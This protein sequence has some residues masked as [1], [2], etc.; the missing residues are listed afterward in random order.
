MSAKEKIAKLSVTA[1]GG[2][3]IQSC[4]ITISVNK[5]PT[6]SLTVLRQPDQKV[7]KPM[8]EEVVAAIRERQQKRLAGLVAPDMVISADDGV[9][10]K[11]DFV[12]Y[13]I[14]PVIQINTVSTT[15]QFTVLG[16]DGMLDALDLSVYDAGYQAARGEA[17]T[18]G[19]AADLI[20]DPIPAADN[21]Q[22]TALISEVS[23]I[24]YGN[25][26]PVRAKEPHQSMQE[27]LDQQ[28]G[29][30]SG[31]PI[32]L[33]L[34]ILANSN[35]VYESWAEAQKTVPG[36]GSQMAL[37]V[38]QILRQ[39][40]GG[41][42]STANALMATYQMYYIPSTTESGKFER[43]DKKV[44][45]NPQPLNL[46]VTGVS[47]SDGNHSLLPIGGVVMMTPAT[48]GVRPESTF[49][50]GT[51]AV[52]AQYPEKLLTGFIQREMPPLWMIGSDG[53]PIV[54]SSIDTK[55]PDKLNLSLP[56]YEKRKTGA[57]DKK[58]EIDNSNNS[59]LVELCK[60]MFNEMQLAHSTAETTIPLDLTQEVGKR[61]TVNILS[62]GSFTAFVSNIIHSIDL[63]QGKELNSFTQISFTHVR[64]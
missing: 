62:G 36:M 41:F 25:Y 37:R 46:S 32:N 57:A 14:V 39:K 45:E 22:V 48:P 47:V 16:V 30:N 11:L 40:V 42:W 20:L 2:Y 35:V 17:S 43:S 31:L 63:R 64:Y 44:E 55:K 50:P 49:E 10:G 53:S 38:K 9:G 3:S 5:V 58:D 23:K 19:R 15:D 60:V 27:L 6:A 26:G 33:W 56:D 12:G 61:V 28:H 8:S 59:V 24:L 4:Q 52:A 29:V 7:R 1:T 13:Q 51:N 21:G 34:R 54:G 18:N